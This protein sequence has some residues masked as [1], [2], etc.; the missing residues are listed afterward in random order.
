MKVV[1]AYFKATMGESLE[2]YCQFES[3]FPPCEYVK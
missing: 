3:I 2:R 1:Y